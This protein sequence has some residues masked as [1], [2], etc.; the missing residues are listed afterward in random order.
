MLVHFRLHVPHRLLFLL[1][2]EEGVE[3]VDS[4]QIRGHSPHIRRMSH[5][6]I[7][8]KRSGTRESSHVYF[9]EECL[10]HNAKFKMAQRCQHGVQ[11]LCSWYS[12][13]SS[14]EI[15][16]EVTVPSS[17]VS[18]WTFSEQSLTLSHI[19]LCRHPYCHTSPRSGDKLSLDAEFMS[20]KSSWT[21]TVLRPSRPYWP[22]FL[23]APNSDNNEPSER[24][25]EN[26]SEPLER[27]RENRNEPLGEREREE[28]NQHEPI[29]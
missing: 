13:L 28:E 29:F 3:A 19:G 12:Q 6:T 9:V 7:H 18:S 10:Q 2:H 16:E 4:S 20:K 27:D 5:R 11:M 1:Q 15:V 14:D 25:R 24:E 21:G 17:K 26:R 23:S 8:P 22:K